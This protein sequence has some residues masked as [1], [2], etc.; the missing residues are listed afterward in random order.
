MGRGWACC[1]I[2]CWACCHAYSC[3]LI[4]FHASSSGC[5]CVCA[6]VRGLTAWVIVVADVG[7]VMVCVCAHWCVLLCCVLVVVSVCAFAF[8]C[9]VRVSCLLCVVSRDVLVA[10]VCVVV[11]CGLLHIAYCVSVIGV[12]AV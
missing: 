4:V 10:V 2:R 12:C 11:A 8:A 1:I 3:C 7:H 6:V 5:L 9:Y